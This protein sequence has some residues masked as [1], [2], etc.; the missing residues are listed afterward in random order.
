MAEDI[1]TTPATSSLKQIQTGGKE[2][3]KAVRWG[4][5]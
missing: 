4:V 3:I 5:V 2:M 1:A